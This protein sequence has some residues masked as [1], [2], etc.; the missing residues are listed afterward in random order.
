MNGEATSTTSIKVQ[1]IVTDP[2][3]PKSFQTGTDSIHNLEERM[4]KR[5]DIS[6]EEFSSK[7]PMFVTQPHDQ[8]CFEGQ[9]A[10]FDCRIEPIGDGSMSVEWY[11][12]GAPIQIGSRIHTINDFGFVVLDIDWTF[13]RDTG[14][15]KCVAK[16]RCGTAEVTANLTCK[17]KKDII[18]DSQLPQ[19]MSTERLKELEQRKAEAAA[20]ADSEVT[21]P[22][23][24]TQIQSRAVGEGE[25]AH[26][27]C[28]VDPKNDPKL[29]IKWFFNEKELASG[30]RFRIT[31]EFGYVALDILY[32]YPD[33]EG[34]Y[35]C[36]AFNELGEDI[37]R[38][39]L[40][41]KELPAIQLENQVPKGMKKS[42]YLVQMEASMKKY[43]TEMFLT[44]DDVYDSERRQPPRF[45]TRI[46]SITSL[47][48]MQATKFECQLAPVG[49]PNMKV[50]WF[51]NGKPLSFK[52]RF[53]PI[54]DFGYVAMNFGWVYPEDSGEYICRATNLFGSDETR[55][56]IKC[57]GKTGIV[58]ESQLP[59][60]MMSIE[61]IREMES[62]WQR[63]P[64]LLETEQEK[65]KPC[66]VT[67][68]EPVTTQEGSSARFCCRVTG[69]PKPRVMWLINGH[70]VING[71][72]HK[73]I[74]DGMWHLDIPKC[75]DR[76]G[77]KIEVI[78][79]NQCGEAYATT[80]L[81][82]KRRKDD[83]RSVL[84][85]NVK[86]DFINSDEYRKPDWLVKMEEIKERLA[87]TEQ[88]PKFI[89]EIKEGRIK[90]GQRAKFE[91]GFAGNPK[92]E[93]TWYFQGQVLKNSKNVQIKIREDSS[94]LTLIDCGFD[95]AGYYECK[96]VNELG[97]DKTRASL[98]VNKMT[99]EEKAEYEKAKANGLLDVV[100]DEEEKVI[101]KKKIK[102]EKKEKVQ[103][104]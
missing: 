3:L 32:T 81:T 11:H 79:R 52:T 55:A 84:K 38:A 68:P 49:D 21:V 23:F 104:K 98:T 71:S 90:E 33:D 76:D 59:K 88:A 27:E 2:Q 18:I 64:E 89:R 9:A 73:L 26:F 102:E 15:Y 1:G 5:E 66:F 41:C 47:E 40:R 39:E 29:Q 56:I 6:Y 28:R 70:T 58:Y 13:K 95:N 24:I 97:S 72:R 53:T 78:A 92:P 4:W 80:T 8:T 82:V 103:K 17:S 43:Q 12:D 62:G 22:K 19:G 20:E 65:F 87:A 101:E 99:S 85:H 44:E 16:N 31:H 74:Y 75:Q 54:Y 63:A 96:A 51:W 69:Y 94:T 42:E 50:E 14:V 46:Q 30:H 37:T 93:V 48:E 61:K 34:E 25:P 10:H 83:Y 60:G 100:A 57:S 77:G 67:K 7:A 91:A 36:K 86:R 35:V 45:V